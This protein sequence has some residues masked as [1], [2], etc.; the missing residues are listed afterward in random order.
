VRLIH[1]RRLGGLAR[2][3][4]LKGDLP[5]QPALR[6]Q[7]AVLVE[8][9]GAHHLG[10]LQGGEAA[11]LVVAEAPL[12]QRAPGL[13]AHLQVAAQFLGLRLKV[14]E[15]IA[16]SDGEP[17]ERGRAFRG[18]EGLRPPEF[19]AQFIGQLRLALPVRVDALAQARG[20]V[21]RGQAG[22]QLGVERLVDVGGQLGRGGE[23]ALGGRGGGG[24]KMGARWT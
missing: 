23:A 24:K 3:L 14:A 20:Q 19:R 8:R 15:R 12:A 5:E 7:E 4:Q 16:L 2:G 18:G 1:R 11:A 17:A 6:G 10:D 13:I 9:V 21:P 22:G